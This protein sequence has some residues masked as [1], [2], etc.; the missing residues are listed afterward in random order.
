MIYHFIPASKVVFSIFNSYPVTSVFHYLIQKVYGV[1]VSVN[2]APE[3]VTVMLVNMKALVCNT[4]QHL[5]VFARKVGTDLCALNRLILV[6]V[7]II[8]VQQVQCVC[9]L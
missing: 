5:L 9:R 8:G 7:A 1:E 3:N 4:V 6:K 2:V